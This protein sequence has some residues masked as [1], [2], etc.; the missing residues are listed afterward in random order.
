MDISELQGSGYT[1]RICDG[2][3]YGY[4]NLEL[5]KSCR[6]AAYCSCQWSF[7]GVMMGMSRSTPTLWSSWLSWADD[8]ST[9]VLDDDVTVIT[10]M[11]TLG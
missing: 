6:C 4:E 9:T 2:Y 1:H 10:G 8:T 5:W 3:R 11:S 7:A